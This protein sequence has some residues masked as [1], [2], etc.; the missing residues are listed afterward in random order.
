MK[1]DNSRTLYDKYFTLTDR[2]VEM[3][4]KDGRSLAGTI[5][6]YCLY[7]DDTDAPAVRYWHFVAGKSDGSAPCSGLGFIPGVMLPHRDI[8]SV[9]FR[10]DGTT[11]RL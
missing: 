4:L 11:L 9:T 5:T 2:F 8:R 6:G 7:D 10:E 1:N 3:E